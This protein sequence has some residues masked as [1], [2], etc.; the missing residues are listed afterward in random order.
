[1]RESTIEHRVDNDGDGDDD[2]RRAVPTIRPIMKNKQEEEEKRTSL[3]VS[4]SLFSRFFRLC[5]GRWIY[6]CVYACE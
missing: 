3:S 2:S 5:V 6:A 1:M 4:M